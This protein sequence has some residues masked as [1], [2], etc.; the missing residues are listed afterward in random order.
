MRVVRPDFDPPHVLDLCSEDGQASL[1][2]L[3]HTK[4]RPMAA[5][6]CMVEEASK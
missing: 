4:Y 1:D 3:W 5:L 2:K 6:V